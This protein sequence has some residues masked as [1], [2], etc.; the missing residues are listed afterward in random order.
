MTP[1]INGFIQAALDLTGYKTSLQRTVLRMVSPVL[2][3]NIVLVIS[4]TE[5]SDEPFPMNVIWLDMGLGSSE[6]YNLRQRVSKTPSGLLSNTWR[7]IT[8]LSD[9]YN[10]QYYDPSDLPDQDHLSP[11]TDTEYGI[12]RLTTAPAAIG[13]P[14]AVSTDDP[15]NFDARHP[16]AHT[17][18]EKPARSFVSYNN[19]V[20]IVSDPAEEGETLIGVSQASAQY[21]RVDKQ[22]LL[23]GN[24]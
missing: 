8:V 2:N 3:S 22:D 7:T 1:T 14:I 24:D 4:P 20:S 21:D 19:P 18:P 15:R 5:P 10:A 6:Y 16:L 17:H 11:A 12:V 23:T 9:V 13:I